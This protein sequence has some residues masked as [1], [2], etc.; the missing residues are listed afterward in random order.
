MRATHVFDRAQNRSGPL[1][2]QSEEFATSV[3][4]IEAEIQSTTS[5][6]SSYSTMMTDT[7]TVTQHTSNIV[8]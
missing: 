6:G 8:S 4:S 3:A 1:P 5:A 7:T 2:Q